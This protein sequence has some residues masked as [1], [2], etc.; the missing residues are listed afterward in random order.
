MKRTAI[1]AVVTT[2][3]ALVWC[4][5]TSFSIRVRTDRADGRTTH[6]YRIVPSGVAAAI[7]ALVSFVSAQSPPEGG[8][9]N[10]PKS[11]AG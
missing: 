11:A 7:L 5:A 10:L 8:C 2:A 9:L 1:F 4:D 3:V 6:W